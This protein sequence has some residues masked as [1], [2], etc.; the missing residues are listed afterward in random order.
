M[1]SNHDLWWLG[2][3]QDDLYFFFKFLLSSSFK[4]FKL[5]I[6][7]LED[8]LFIRN[9]PILS[10][11]SSKANQNFLFIFMFKTQIEWDHVFCFCHN[12]C[13]STVNNC[14]V[15]LRLV[16]C[17]VFR[18]QFWNYTCMCEISFRYLR[19]IF[20][21]ITTML[22]AVHVPYSALCPI[23]RMLKCLL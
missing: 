20:L 21:N 1:N 17:P 3:K 9:F 22:E 7:T 13:T 19:Q 8:L 10:M 6:P 18:V 15:K 23:E 5:R 4:Y 2:R 12:L 11:A 14:M 16:H